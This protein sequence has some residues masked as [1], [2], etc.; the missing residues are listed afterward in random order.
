MKRTNTSGWLIMSNARGLSLAAGLAAA[1]A[2][3][4][5]LP[6]AAQ[7]V[8]STVQEDN[9]ATNNAT[10]D[11]GST[12]DGNQDIYTGA[13]TN[14][15]AV[16]AVGGGATGTG[17]DFTG[18]TLPSS[19]MALEITL[20][21]INGNSATAQEESDSG[22]DPGQQTN[23]ANYNELVLYLGGTYDATTGLLTGGE[24]VT[25]TGGTPLYLNGLLGESLQSTQSYVANFDATEG[26]A[27]LA[28][29]SNGHLSAFIAT[30]NPDDT[31]AAQAGTVGDGPAEVFVGNGD[32]PSDAATTLTLAVPEPG[33]VNLVLAGGGLLLL[34]GSVRARR[35]ARSLSL[36]L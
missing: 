21:V 14:H 24:E 36:N 8:T 32:S 4:F 34:A 27:I 19:I 17:Y 23:D 12:N 1:F 3:G 7:S 2:L 33:T 22:G 18:M 28:Q 6:A 13:G 10:N 11:P 9:G 31:S 26:A 20:T 16:I 29:I 15:P 35:A 25:Q 30:L 5:A